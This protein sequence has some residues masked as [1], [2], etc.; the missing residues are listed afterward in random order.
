[1]SPKTVGAFTDMSRRLI[2]QS[3]PDVENMVRTDLTKVVAEAIDK[4]SLIGGGTNE[5]TGIIADTNVPVVAIGTN[6][7]AMTYS[8]LVTLK[9]HPRTTTRLVASKCSSSTARP[10]RTSA[11]LSKLAG[12]RITCLRRTAPCSDTPGF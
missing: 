10:R 7:G 2:L 12:I 1:M 3:T 5:P 4:A 9:L 8:T 11:R 6:G